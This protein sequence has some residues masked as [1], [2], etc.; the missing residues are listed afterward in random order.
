MWIDPLKWQAK[1][2]FKTYREL[3]N[4]VRFSVYSHI[5]SQYLAVVALKEYE[6]NAKIPKVYF[7]ISTIGDF[8]KQYICIKFVSRTIRSVVKSTFYHTKISWKEMRNKEVTFY[9]HFRLT[10]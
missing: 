8:L 2:L 7:F 5:F 10:F 6:Y 1:T 3:S 9:E 4:F